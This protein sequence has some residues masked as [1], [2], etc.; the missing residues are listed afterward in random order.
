[1][2]D[3]FEYIYSDWENIVITLG[4]IG[5]VGFWMMLVAAMRAQRGGRE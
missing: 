2:K 3:T 4:F 5:W 1:M